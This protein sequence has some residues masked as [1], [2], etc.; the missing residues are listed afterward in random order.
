MRSQPFKK[1]RTE[2]IEIKR[3]NAL[4]GKSR[5][6]PSDDKGSKPLSELISIDDF[7]KIDLRVGEVKSAEPVKGAT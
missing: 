6:L 3:Q 7:G 1:C 4:L 5:D 2:V